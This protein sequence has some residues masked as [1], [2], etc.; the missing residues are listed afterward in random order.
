LDI[1]K[2]VGEKDAIESVIQ[3]LVDGRLLVSDRVENQDVIDLSHEALMLSWKR[4]VGWREND[5]EVRRIVDKIESDR[6]EWEYHNQDPSYFPKRSLLRTIE[7]QS[8]LICPQL[9]IAQLDFYIAAQEYLEKTQTINQKFENTLHEGDVN[10]SNIADTV[11]FSLDSTM[12]E[13]DFNVS[14]TANTVNFRLEK[15]V[16]REES[17]F[18]VNGT[19]V[20]MRINDSRIPF[21]F[22]FSVNGSSVETPPLIQTDQ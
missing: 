22:H 15:C 5:R 11:N 13:S 21:P 9:S 17:N 20:D 12:C 1:G 18:S 10:I 7:T 4:F 8:E 14:I 3:T 16:F 2:D 6:C 19:T